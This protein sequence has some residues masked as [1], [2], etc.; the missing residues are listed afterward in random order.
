MIIFNGDIGIQFPFFTYDEFKE[1]K[2]GYYLQE[3]NEVEDIY[4]N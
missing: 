4:T 3:E 1:H 2:K